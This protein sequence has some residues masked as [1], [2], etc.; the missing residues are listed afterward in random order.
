MLLQHFT[1]M[2]VYTG[3]VMKVVKTILVFSA[4]MQH[5]LRDALD[6]NDYNSEN[7]IF[8]KVA[9]NLMCSERTC[10]LETVNFVTYPR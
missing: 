10:Y 6:L 5:M 8:A 4:G 2:R 3:T 9:K 1:E 7:L